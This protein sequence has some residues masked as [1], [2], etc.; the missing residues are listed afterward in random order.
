MDPRYS[1][2]PRGRLM[3]GIVAAS[4]KHRHAAARGPCH[5]FH[6]T[7]PLGLAQGCGLARRSAGDKERDTGFNLPVHQ[8]MKR[9]FVDATVP[10]KGSYQRC[11]TTH[12]FHNSCKFTPLVAAD[13]WSA[14]AISSS[15][16]TKDQKKAPAMI[17]RGL[18]FV[19]RKLLRRT[20]PS[21]D[22][23]RRGCGTQAH[24]ARR[25]QR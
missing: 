2:C 24:A 8:R 10:A 17:C 11:S 6:H 19:E 7:K 5:Q 25:L 22:S 21:C 14:I 3:G 20:F 23:V 16:V 18:S 1:A 9:R 12:Q 13:V 4:C 15:D